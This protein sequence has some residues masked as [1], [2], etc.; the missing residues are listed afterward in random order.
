ME[1]SRQ[2]KPPEAIMA[3]MGP[4]GRRSNHKQSK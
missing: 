1:L 3:S 2:G 4:D